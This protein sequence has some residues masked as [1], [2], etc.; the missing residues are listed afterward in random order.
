MVKLESAGDLKQLQLNLY[1]DSSD[2]DKLLSK[3]DCIASNALIVLGLV[4]S[5][6]VAITGLVIGFSATSAALLVGGSLATVIGAIS[7]CLLACKL[8]DCADIKNIKKNSSILDFKKTQTC[9]EQASN[10]SESLDLVHDTE[11]I[12][13]KIDA[14]PSISDQV[15]NSSEIQKYLLSSSISLETKNKIYNSM[16]RLFS[17]EY[18]SPTVQKKYSKSSDKFE[19]V[20]LITF[21]RYLRGRFGSAITRSF[22]VEELCLPNESKDNSLA[23]IDLSKDSQISISNPACKNDPLDS[24][25]QSGK[26]LSDRLVS[27][28]SRHIQHQ[29]DVSKPNTKIPLTFYLNKNHWTLGFVDLEKM[30]LEYYDS[31][32][33]LAPKNLEIALKKIALENNLTYLV[34]NQK[35]LQDNGYDCGVWHSYFLTK[36]LENLHFDPNQISD[37]NADEIIQKFRIHMLTQIVLEESL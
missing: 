35:K 11:K 8:V 32:G 7:L 31:F 17:N 34:K 25:Q 26:E 28:I 5:F 33:S 9:G 3:V 4:F 2:T 23:V 14:K 29:R 21:S 13:I 37:K 36:R 22:D 1:K 10:L 15:F 20:E 16:E 19:A 30:T 24:D 6:A 12:N 18:Y 27:T